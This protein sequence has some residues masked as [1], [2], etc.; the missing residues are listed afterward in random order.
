[1]VIWCDRQGRSAQTDRSDQRAGPWH[2]ETTGEPASRAAL[3]DLED[4]ERRIEKTNANS[5]NPSEREDQFGAKWIAWVVCQSAEQGNSFDEDSFGNCLV[6]QLGV[7]KDL[8]R[9][10]EFY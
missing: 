3:R 10:A 9:V 4:S 5:A 8:N 6:N 1:M 2:K 7:G